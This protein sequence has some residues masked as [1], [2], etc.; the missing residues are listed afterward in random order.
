MLRSRFIC[1]FAFKCYLSC[2][3]SLTYNQL[4]SSRCRFYCSSE[5]IW[6]RN[7]KLFSEYWVLMFACRTKQTARII[8]C[9]NC[10]PFN[11]FTPPLHERIPTSTDCEFIIVFPTLES[12]LRW[13]VAMHDIIAGSIHRSCVVRHWLLSAVYT[14]GR[15]LLTAET[16]HG[17]DHLHAQPVSSCDWVYIYTHYKMRPTAIR[18]GHGSGRQTGG[19]WGVKGHT[20]PRLKLSSCTPSV[21]SGASHAELSGNED[22]LGVLARWP[23]S[24]WGRDEQVE[25]RAVWMTIGSHAAGID[26]SRGRSIQGGL[27]NHGAHVCDVDET[28][29]DEMRWRKQLH[30]IA[31]QQAL[32]LSL[33]DS[34]QSIVYITTHN[35]VLTHWWARVKNRYVCIA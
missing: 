20:V 27:G 9:W 24:S 2:Y 14:G 5:H 7:F 23:R 28:R 3:Y 21:L 10:N 22:Q 12:K 4:F 1:Y 19:Q 17:T 29:R 18:W 30:Q 15:G 11:W 32:I 16:T 26:N 25:R 13:H 35:P 8:K 31:V 34:Q 6:C 33:K